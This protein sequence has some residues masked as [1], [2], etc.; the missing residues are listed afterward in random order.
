MVLH[1]SKTYAY[2]QTIYEQFYLVAKKC[3][4]N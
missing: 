1:N 4:A 3:E 2:Y